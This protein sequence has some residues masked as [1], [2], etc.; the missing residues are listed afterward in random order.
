MTNHRPKHLLKSP[1]VARIAVLMLLWLMLTTSR[2]ADAQIG[3]T[4]TQIC[5]AQG[6]QRRGVEFSPGGIILTTF[7]KTAMWVYNIDSDRRYPLPDTAPCGRN[8]RLSRD[9]RWIT[10]YDYLNGTYNQM[11]LDGTQR[12]PLANYAVDIEWWTADMLLVWTPGHLAYLR[13]ASEDIGREYLDVAGIVSVQP[14]GHWGLL[15]EQDGDV[16]NRTLV[17]LQSRNLPGI[18]EQRI[19]LGTDTPYFNASSWSPNGQFVYVTSGTFDSSV[20]IAGGEIYGIRPEIEDTPQQWTDFNSHYGAVRINGHAFSEL[21]WSPDGTYIAFW[22]IELLGTDAE[23]N[24]GSATIHVLN[25]HT[26]E[27]RAYC[28]FTTNEHTPN[29]SRLIWSPDGT[30]I[31]FGGNVPGDDKGYLLLVMNVETGQLTELSDGIYPALGSA[32]IIA[33][34]LAP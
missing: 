34:G 26:L 9:A 32:D 24:T 27:V 33:W 13:P 19:P 10:Y 8:C 11:H 1:S 29:P 17:N 28:G 18:A 21:S 2:T 15:I 23:A 30:H 16:F 4:L 25:T 20:G 6:I 14:G 7:D 3:G 5:P 22:V 12:T 31:A